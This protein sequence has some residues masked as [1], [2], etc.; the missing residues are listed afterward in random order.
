MYTRFRLVLKIDD[1]NDFWA[2]FNVTDSLNAA[3]MTKYSL[4]LVMIPSPCRVAGCII[5]IL[6]LR[7]NA[8]AH[9]LTYLLR[10]TSVFDW[11]VI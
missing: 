7:I 10:I 1:F 8:P 2:R 11:R 6:G 9:L 5:T 4:G 3:K